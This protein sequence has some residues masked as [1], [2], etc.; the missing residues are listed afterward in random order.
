MM[1]RNIYQD[2][3]QAE[4]IQTMY[5]MREAASMDVAM[6]M[7]AFFAYVATAYFVGKRLSIFQLIVVSIMYVAFMVFNI[8]GINFLLTQFNLI[9]GII[10]PETAGF[11]TGTA[12]LTILIL[13]LILSLGFMI[14]VRLRGTEEPEQE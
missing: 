12:F 13:G 9:S 11:D 4:L 10:W 2:M 8:M 14:E 6:Y 1:D 3:D 5:L 7:T